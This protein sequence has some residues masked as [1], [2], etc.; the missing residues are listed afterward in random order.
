[1]SLSLILLEEFYTDIYPTVPGCP[2]MTIENAVR[3]AALGFCE[4]TGI[5]Q[6]DMDPITVVS[7]QHEY[8]FESPDE[9]IVHSILNANYD[10]HPLTVLSSKLIEQRYPRHREYNGAPEGIF[11]KDACIFKLYPVPDTTKVNSLYMTVVVK[12]APNSEYVPEL[13]L[14]DHKQAIVDGAL[15]RLLMLPTKDWTNGALAGAHTAAFV[16]AIT[17]ASRRARRGDEGAAPKTKY[18]G[19]SG[20]STRRGWRKGWR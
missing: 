11:R 2:E 10:G 7:G 1:M 15:A 6:Y 19:I 4:K 16:G 8:D 14:N 17:E 12:P 18:G 20:N 9:M 13:L 5:V 3:A